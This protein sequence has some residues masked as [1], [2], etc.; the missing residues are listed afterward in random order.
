MH[1]NTGN[2][3]RLE[4]GM[5]SQG[6]GTISTYELPD[7]NTG[8]QTL[9]LCNSSIRSLLP[10]H[11]SRLTLAVVKMCQLP[12]GSVLWGHF[13]SIQINGNCWWSLLFFLES[14]K[15]F[16]NAFWLAPTVSWPRVEVLQVVGRGYGHQP[17]LRW[18]QRNYPILL[19]ELKGW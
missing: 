10:N 17:P 18:H 8:N 12:W 4:E 13:Q 5:R 15:L 2:L 19:S 3:S 9:A 16:E 7:M 11:F 14:L 6:A 1:M